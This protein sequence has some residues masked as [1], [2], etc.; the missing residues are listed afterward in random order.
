MR[1]IYGM[2]YYY[3]LGVVGACL[4]LVLFVPKFVRRVF[5]RLWDG[6]QLNTATK[7]LFYGIMLI[8]IL[9]LVDSVNTYYQYR[10]ILGTRNS[11]SIQRRSTHWQKAKSITSASI[12]NPESSTWPSVTSCSLLPRYSQRSCCIAS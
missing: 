4:L 2:L 7:F 8:N 9:V 11:K 5:F 3:L 1:V 12:N 6:I 10:D